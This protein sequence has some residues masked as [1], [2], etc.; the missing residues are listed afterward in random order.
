VGTL[1]DECLVKRTR[2][3]LLKGLEPVKV[4]VLCHEGFSMGIWQR[5][6]DGDGWVEID[7]NRMNEPDKTEE[8]ECG[9]HRDCL[10]L[11]SAQ[12][13]TSHTHA[14]GSVPVTVHN[15]RIVLMNY[16]LLI[17]KS[18]RSRIIVT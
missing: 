14:A 7:L 13:G 11:Q 10:T 5:S 2:I 6:N 4:K 3:E 17:L 9:P 1:P 15:S 18:I 8:S 16:R 12:H